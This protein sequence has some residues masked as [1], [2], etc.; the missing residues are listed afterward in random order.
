[1]S[2]TSKSIFQYRYYDLDMNFPFLFLDGDRWYLTKEVM[3]D[4]HFHNCL[5]IG[6]CHLNK[7]T[8]LFEGTPI[9]FKAGDVTCIPKHI[10]HNTFSSEEGESL[11][12]FIF[13]DMNE[14]FADFV[15]RGIN[16]SNFEFTVPSIEQFKFI[17]SRDEYP[18]VH[19]LM[20][21]IID[22]MRTKQSDYKNI[23][24][25]YVLA[26]YFEFERIQNIAKTSEVTHLNKKIKKESLPILPALQFI[27]N[28]YMSPIHI[29][30]LSELC[31][32]S[33]THFRRIFRQIMGCSPL[34]YVNTVRIEK[35]CNLIKTTDRS[36]LSISQDVGFSSISCFNRAF[37]SAT[38]KT[39]RK[40]R[41]QSEIGDGQ[42]DRKMVVAYPG[43]T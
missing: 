15:N 43:W 22:E 14:L 37:M 36:I 33:E 35:A 17:I 5:E 7:G 27:G 4:Y 30:Q 10:P 2:R 38:K 39:P 13:V 21:R 1:M 32:L 24:K 16:K 23:V 19:F 29:K 42:L 11:W 26:L 28:N 9:D 41:Y 12:T 25:S 6:Y 18:S 31:F 20:T 8:M 34:A 40:F 3:R